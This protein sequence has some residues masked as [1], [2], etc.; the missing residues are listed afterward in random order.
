MANESIDQTI[1]NDLPTQQISHKS[2]EMCWARIIFILNNAHVLFHIR[3]VKCFD[4]NIYLHMN[5]TLHSQVMKKKT[6]IFILTS[7]CQM[8]F[9]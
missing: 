3:I 2:I 1:L 4:I 5:T 9:I 8:N 6:K 7:T